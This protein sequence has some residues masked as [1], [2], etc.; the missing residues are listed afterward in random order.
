MRVRVK[1]VEG[2][3][4]LVGNDGS[5]SKGKGWMSTVFK[6]LQSEVNILPLLKQVAENWDDW[7]V[8]TN[9]QKNLRPQKESMEIRLVEGIH[10][11]GTGIEGKQKRFDDSNETLKTKLYD[12]Y[13]EC[14]YFLNW[15]LKTYGGKLYR[16]SIVHLPAGGKV[17]PHKDG[18]KYYENKNRFHLVLSGYY[19]Y[20]VGDETQRLG[21]GDLFWF[22][23]QKM[24]SSANATPIPRISLI[25]DV[26]GCTI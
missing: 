12:K 22:D 3:K 10:L 18:G 19:D 11:P 24:H 17:Y 21:A 26:E 25:F 2:R 16:V 5:K 13:N 8:N 1:R 6:R 23:N 9:R 15:F 14:V 20:T 4:L 7:Y